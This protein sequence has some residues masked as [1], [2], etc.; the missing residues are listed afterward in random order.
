[1]Y[2]RIWWVQNVPTLDSLA[3]ISHRFTSCAPNISTTWYT[4]THGGHANKQR[5]L[6]YTCA[7]AWHGE[8]K[9]KKETNNV[10]CSWHHLAA[11][12]SLAWSVSRACR[13]PLVLAMRRSRLSRARQSS[14]SPSAIRSERFS[15]DFVYG[16]KRRNL[17]VE[18]CDRLL[19]APLGSIESKQ[20][21]QDVGGLSSKKIRLCRNRMIGRKL[22]QQP[23][24]RQC[25]EK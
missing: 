7:P 13:F 24:R 20:Y 18:G 25:R 14:A 23:K 11:S 16:A 9:K 8:R 5:E 22:K 10:E 6:M 17:R 1:M 12:S 15:L 4:S 3:M 19:E 2:G 21:P